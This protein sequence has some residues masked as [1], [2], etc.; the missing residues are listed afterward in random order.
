MY[1][2][3]EL[4][5]GLSTRLIGRKL[6]V[7]DHIDSTN[8][9]AKALGDAGTDE[10]AV[11]LT[12]FQTQ[13]KGRLGRTWNAEPGSN[14]LFTV[15]LRPQLAEETSN[16]LTFFAAVAV[17]KAI[18]FVTKRTIECKWPN[19]LLLNGKKCCGILLE[20][21]FKKNKLDYSVIGI[22]LNV[23]QKV[24]TPELSL[25]ATSLA[26]ECEAEFDRK[27]LLHR[28]L[29]Q[30]DFLYDDVRVGQFDRVLSEWQERSSMIGKSVTVSGYNNSFTGTVMSI[31]TNGGLIIKTARGLATVYAGDVQINQ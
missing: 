31:S 18:E 13:G 15:L 12:D 22:G 7:F 28:I 14:L 3:E 25:S 23:N 26:Q 5:R 4:Q 19:D 1:S 27:Q 9:C 6:F 21:S 11:V 17:A 16:L 29:E 8:T 30:M 20:S 2:K 24:F 10:G